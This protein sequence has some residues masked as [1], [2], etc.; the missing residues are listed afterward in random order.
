M[1]ANGLTDPRQ[2]LAGETLIVPNGQIIDRQFSYA[3]FPLLPGAYQQFIWPVDVGFVSSPFGIRN[4]VMH[5][6][7]DIAAGAGTTIHAAGDGTVIFSGRLHG[8][9]NAII[10]RHLD[11]YVTVYGHNQ[12]NLVF[13]GA[14]VTRGQAIAE[15]GATGRATGPNLHFE[16]RYH[17]QPQDPLAFLPPQA[18]GNVRFARNSGS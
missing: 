6:G 3:R 4:G 17:G 8:Y 10:L 9:G 2:L 7:I 13:R 5:D 18:N 14:H 16:V 1:A 15:L 12:R 11:G